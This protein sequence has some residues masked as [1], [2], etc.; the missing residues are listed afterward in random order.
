MRNRR[1]A[2]LNALDSLESLRTGRR[3]ILDLSDNEEDVPP[4]DG[5]IDDEE[6]VEMESGGD[7]STCSSEDN[8]DDEEE[9]VESENWRIVVPEDDERDEI[10]PFSCVTGTRSDLRP[11]SL[12]DD[13]LIIKYCDLFLPS[14]L[15]DMLVEFTNIRAGLSDDPKWKPTNSDELRKFLCLS[16]L[17][18]IVR[19]PTFQS[20]WST[21]G[22]I[23]TPFF[24]Q[25]ESLSRD[26]FLQLLRYIRFA[27]YTQLPEND[28]LRK[29]RPFLDCVKSICKETYH[30]SKYVSV[31]ETLLLFKG[32]FIYKQFIPSKRA[33][34][35]VKTYA[36]C[37]SE[38]GYMYNFETYVAQKN[39]DFGEFANMP[40]A[41]KIVLLLTKPLFHLGH[42]VVTD[43]FF[44]SE[45]L[46]SNLLRN[47]TYFTGTWRENRRV[48]DILK[49]SQSQPFETTF[50]RKG[51]LL[52]SKF[53]DKK[54]SGKKN[55]YVLDSEELASSVPVR[56]IR[57]GGNEELID[58][59]TTI[60]KYNAKMGGV[61]RTDSLIQRYDVTRKSLNWMTKYGLH[62][63]QRL[64]MNAHVAYCSD[65]GSRTF[66]K[67][68]LTFI[69]R[70]MITTGEMF[71][72][73]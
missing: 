30:P 14:R 8:D 16:L 51:L 43:N 37:E 47:G 66:L 58:K 29:I 9:E 48:P 50:A 3:Q 42:H 17:M 19:K 52:C 41:S 35:G 36:L 12:D 62:L 71:L 53:V 70:T 72:R 10:Y 40:F 2:L 61:D 54:Q 39:I 56:R 33:R 60:L 49:Y 20:Y 28:V 65:G 63:I 67:F 18:G 1:T 59:P 45:H 31:D 34:Y 5:N 23:S 57:K 21:D 73:L 11:S 24:A 68:T 25:E 64:L 13:E 22:I 44:T 15:V 4:D 27:D 26:R 38:T 55:I 6:D 7:S 69:E 46:A 32:R